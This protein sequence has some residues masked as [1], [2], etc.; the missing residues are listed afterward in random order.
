VV[1]VMSQ[2]LIQSGRPNDNKGD[3]FGGIGRNLDAN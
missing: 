3:Y 1:D 2:Q